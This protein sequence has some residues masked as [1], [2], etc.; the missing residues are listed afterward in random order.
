MPCQCLHLETICFYTA[1]GR[2]DGEL[3]YKVQQQSTEAQYQQNQ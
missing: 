3:H 1:V 2:S